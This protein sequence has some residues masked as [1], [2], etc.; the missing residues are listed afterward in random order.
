LSFKFRAKNLKKFCGHGE[1]W[2]FYRGHDESDHI[3]GFLHFVGQ[4][5]PPIE[6]R[7]QAARLPYKFLI[8]MPR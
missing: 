6:L 2:L 5:F 7:W 8:L 4:A 1:L 3:P